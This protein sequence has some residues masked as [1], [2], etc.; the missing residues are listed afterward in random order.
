LRV[1]I[2]WLPSEPINDCF[3]TTLMSLSDSDWR[4]S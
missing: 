1:N 3:R 2:W 4:C